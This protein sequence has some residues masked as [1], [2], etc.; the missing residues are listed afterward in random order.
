MSTTDTKAQIEKMFEA[1]AHYAFSK[2]RRHPSAKPFIF[3]SK[4]NTE[5]FNLEK[6]VDTLEE[7][8][9]KVRE[10][11]ENGKTILFLSSKAEAREAV[12]EGAERINQPYVVDRWIG[13]TLTNFPQ[14]RKR[15]ARLEDLKKKRDKGELSKFTKKERLLIDREIEALES[16][17]GGIAD[18]EKLPDALFIVDSR[19]ETIAINEATKKNIPIIAL[20][21]SDCDASQ[22]TTP[23]FGNDATRKSI[24]FFVNEI[25]SA[26]EE[27]AK[28]RK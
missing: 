16:K 26:Y 22:I 17:F 19:E 7:A 14:M 11:A 28:K 1:G 27:G 5:I 4:D 25:T 2:S 21:N 23:I 12:V 6:T 3:G 9:N 8:K 13:G 18:M 20:V 24:S 10:F 15:V